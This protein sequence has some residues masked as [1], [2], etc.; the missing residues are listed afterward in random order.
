MKAKWTLGLVF[1]MGAGLLAPVAADA[2]NECWREAQF[3]CVD[4]DP[5]IRYLIGYDLAVWDGGADNLDIGYNNASLCGGVQYIKLGFSCKK[6]GC[7]KEVI[8]SYFIYKYRESDL[9]GNG[10]TWKK[11]KKYYKKN[12]LTPDHGDAIRF[13]PNSGTPTPAVTNVPQQ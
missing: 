8:I 5:N 13:A 10:T 4:P 2:G 11:V 9:E 7:D 6:A 3:K 12:N 1:C